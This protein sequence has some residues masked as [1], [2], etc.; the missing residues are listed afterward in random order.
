MRHWSVHW[1][2]IPAIIPAIPEAVQAEQGHPAHPAVPGEVPA[3][4]AGHQ[5][6]AGQE[7]TEAEAIKK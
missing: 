5:E 1:L 2:L 7:D 6:E 3:V 4:E